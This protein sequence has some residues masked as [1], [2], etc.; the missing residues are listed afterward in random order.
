MSED[1]YDLGFPNLTEEDLALIDSKEAEE[2]RSFNVSTK[3]VEIEDAVLSRHDL[4][5]GRD[6][7]PFAQYRRNKG[8]FSVTDLVSPAW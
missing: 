1:E 5:G 6:Q 2:S 7:S 8:T 3:V 4:E